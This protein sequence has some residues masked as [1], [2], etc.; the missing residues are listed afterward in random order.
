[1]W[2]D[3][4]GVC[5]VPSSHTLPRAHMPW[6]VSS[7]PS[8]FICPH[9]H[10]RGHILPAFCLTVLQS[11]LSLFHDLVGPDYLLEPTRVSAEGAVDGMAR[12]VGKV[13]GCWVKGGTYSMDIL[14]LYN[15]GWGKES[16]ISIY[17][18]LGI[19]VLENF[20]FISIRSHI[21]KKIDIYILS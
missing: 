3:S 4:S 20:H 21:K 1:M 9:P 15:L 18:K 2:S 11:H 19:C 7:P 16:H 13:T 14:P 5:L 8:D 17:V 6:S 12:G 10:P